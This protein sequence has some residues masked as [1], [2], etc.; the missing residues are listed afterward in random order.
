MNATE[1]IEGIEPRSRDR[2]GGGQGY[3]REVGGA[4]DGL[5]GEEVDD[6]DLEGVVAGDEGRQGE[7]ALDGDLFAGLLELFGG[8]VLF[9]DLLAVF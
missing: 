9:P 7:V 3:N 2:L 1:K 5:I 8:F 4:G 6:V